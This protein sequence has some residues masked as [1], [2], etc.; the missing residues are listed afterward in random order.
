MISPSMTSLAKFAS[1]PSFVAGMTSTFPPTPPPPTPST[2]KLC[3][4]GIVAMTRTFFVPAVTDSIVAEMDATLFPL[5]D[6]DATIPI[7]VTS[8][9]FPFTFMELDI[10][11]V[12]GPTIT[13]PPPKASRNLP[14][15]SHLRRAISY[16]SSTFAYIPS[17]SSPTFMARLLMTP[18]A[19]LPIRPFPNNCS[20]CSDDIRS[21]FF[22]VFFFGD[23]CRCTDAA[24]SDDVF[25]LNG[26]IFSKNDSVLESSSSSSVAKKGER[27][28]VA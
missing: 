16:A 24:L 22:V 21:R 14:S 23:D 2:S 27:D 5:A 4:L 12:T 17:Y 15:R 8:V 13:S 1:S 28:I 18:V 25:F 11:I 10:C 7:L 19:T 20:L 3:P 26:F 6:D 9:F